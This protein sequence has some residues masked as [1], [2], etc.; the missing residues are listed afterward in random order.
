MQ[1]LQCAIGVVTCANKV[2]IRD[3]Q[4]EISMLNSYCGKLIAMKH[5]KNLLRS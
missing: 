2:T 5:E 1:D 3:M 4:Y